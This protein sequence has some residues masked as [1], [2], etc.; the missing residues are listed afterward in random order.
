MKTYMQINRFLFFIVVLFIGMQGIAQ[1]PDSKPL[2]T[3]EQILEMSY[4]QLL[5]MPFEELIKLAEVVGVSAEELLQM[6]LN[7]EVTSASKSEETIFDSPLSISMITAEEISISGATTIEEA[8]R[9]I[10]GVIVREKTNGNYDVHIRGLDNIPP[11]NM[12]LY[13]ENSMSL[14]MIDNRVVYN[15][16]HGGAFW[17]TLPIGLEDVE[18]IEVIRGPASAL[19]GPNAVTG[20]IHIITKKFEKTKKHINANI[21]GGL[22][23]TIIAGLN[24]G[25]KLNKNF[26]FNISGNYQY[27]ERFQEEFYLWERQKY[28]PRDSLATMLVPSVN[29]PYETRDL[30]V[31]FPNPKLGRENYG[32][33]LALF[34]DLNEKIKFD[35][36]SGYQNSN[37]ITTPLDNPYYSLTRRT[38]E[39]K[40]IDFKAKAYGLNAQLSYLSGPQQVAVDVLGMQVDCHTLDA[41]LEY[42][43]KYKNLGIRPGITYRQTNYDDSKYVNVNIKEG[44]LNGNKMLSTL[45]YGLRLDYLAFSKLRLIGALRADK[46][47]NPD[48]TY[49]T[50]QAV[51]SY[52]LNDKHMFRAVYSRA[53]RSPFIVDIYANFDWQ[54]METAPFLNNG[55]HFYFNGNKELKLATMDMFEVGYRAN[56]TKNIQI[57]IEAFSSKTNNFDWFQLDTINLLLVNTIVLSTGTPA[58]APMQVPY[59]AVFTYR[60]SDLVAKQM[61]V[62]FDIT[63]VLS[64]NIYCKVFGTIQETKLENFRPLTV[65]Q[66]IATMAGE[67]Y[68]SSRFIALPDSLPDGALAPGTRTYGY[69]FGGSYRPDNKVD[70]IHKSTPSFFGGFS[71]NYAPTKKINFNTNIYY[72]S[73]QTLSHSFESIDIDPKV[74]VSA[75]VSYKLMDNLSVYL[76]ARNLMNN[77]TKEFA[78]VDDIGGMYLIGV[79]YKF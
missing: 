77:K 38:S 10:P 45:S 25:A 4:E 46:Y 57:D 56:P 76:N 40:Y 20:V 8:L 30:D 42:D 66:S 16:A 23:N 21:Q 37:S 61:G 43:Y 26:R 34:Y 22:P 67:A 6:I 13:S 75:K 28:V 17:E 51:A 24:A 41:I 39:T 74:I 49:L 31:R 32:A 2:P 58:G 9:L 73:K 55:V 44:F 47:N 15:Y 71:L 79:D 29:K 14:I 64:K 65:N 63:A 60:N 3:K 52:N 72:Y 50:Y 70:T 69:K 78:F 5:N 54:V 68:A 33:N 11:G 48:K 19:Y 1:Q 27:R 53:N 62:S 18:R 7:K 36:T 35:L 59:N 12:L